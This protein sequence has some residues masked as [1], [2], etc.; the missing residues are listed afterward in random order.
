MSRVVSGDSRGVLLHAKPIFE[1]HALH[2]FC[3]VMGAPSPM[4]PLRGTLRQFAHHR[5]HRDTG[6]TAVRLGRASAHGSKRRFHRLSR[7]HWVPVL[8]RASIKRQELL[9]VLDQTLGRLG[10]L[11]FIRGN[12]HGKGPLRPLAVGRHPERLQALCG[13]RLHCSGREHSVV[14]CG[15][16]LTFDTDQSPGTV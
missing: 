16:T 13:L 11:R 15:A 14:L 1:D 7:A 4:P 10:R 3:Q 2:D 5:Q 8:G 9:A 12:A 6:E